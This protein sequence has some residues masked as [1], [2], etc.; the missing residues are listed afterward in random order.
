MHIGRP[1]RAQ[2]RTVRDEKE[3]DGIGWGGP[4][5]QP[6]SVSG[7]STGARGGRTGRWPPD[8]QGSTPPWSPL[9]VRLHGAV[10]GAS[11]AVFFVPCRRALV[12]THP[13]QW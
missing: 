13:T 7:A 9:S 11:V 8:A 1:G 10:S 3:L 6:V 5:N 4:Q 2:G 12:P